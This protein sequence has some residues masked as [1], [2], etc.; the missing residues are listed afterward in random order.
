MH[1][2][3]TIHCLSSR[4]TAGRLDKD[5]PSELEGPVS[6]KGRAGLGVLADGGKKTRMFLAAGGKEGPH[7][8]AISIAGLR[9]GGLGWSTREMHRPRRN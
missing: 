6:R 1:A 8:T 5:A 3:R 9:A 7:T 2:L 4:L